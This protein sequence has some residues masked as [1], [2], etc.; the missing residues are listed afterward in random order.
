MRAEVKAHGQVEL[1][2]VVSNSS[3][4]HFL[5][6]PFLP[7]LECLT[8]G[9]FCDSDTIEDEALIF[10]CVYYDVPRLLLW[11]IRIWEIPHAIV[12][13]PNQDCENMIRNITVKMHEHRTSSISTRIVIHDL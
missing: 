2:P 10:G 5:Y 8:K 13:I 12:L 6:F 4:L 1:L 3:A 7:L 11:E 9:Y